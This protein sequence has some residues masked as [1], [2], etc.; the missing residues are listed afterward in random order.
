MPRVEELFQEME[1]L[2]IAEKWRLVRRMLQLLEQEQVSPPARSDWQQFLHET[3]GSLRD[4][5]LQRWDQG[6]YEVREPI[7]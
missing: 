2:P 4:T 5:P 6:D 3:Y 1:R 7:E